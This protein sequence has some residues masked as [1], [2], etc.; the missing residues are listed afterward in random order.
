SLSKKH[1][2]TTATKRGISNINTVKIKKVKVQKLENF[3]KQFGVPKYIKIDVEGYEYEV[4]L[5]LET[6]VPL[7]SFEV[8]LPEFSEEAIKTLDYLDRL[9]KGKYK[10][11][12]STNN[13]LILEKYIA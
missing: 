3:I 9:S 5:G 13:C 4:L 7:L 6:P 12:Y 10:Y 2:K 1:I 8:N 11:N